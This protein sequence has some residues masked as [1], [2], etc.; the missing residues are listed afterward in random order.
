MFGI[1]VALVYICLRGI[2]E[3][4]VPDE[5]LGA[6]PAAPVPVGSHHGTDEVGVVLMGCR[7]PAALYIIRWRSRGD[8]NQES[9]EGQELHGGSG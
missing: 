6:V 5:I 1:L 8:S 9:K 3:G 7:V 4:R 2:G